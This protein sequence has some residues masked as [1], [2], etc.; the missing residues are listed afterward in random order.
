MRVE[1]TLDELYNAEA[2]DMSL[3]DVQNLNKLVNV[4]LLKAGFKFQSKL[5]RCV[6]NNRRCIVYEWDGG[7]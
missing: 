4:K 2:N 5:K 3:S 7:R 1:V 6:D